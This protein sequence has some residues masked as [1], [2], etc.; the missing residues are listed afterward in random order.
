MNHAHDRFHQGNLG[1]H[2][3]TRRQPLLQAAKGGVLRAAGF[4]AFEMCLALAGLLGVEQPF[5]A[6]DQIVPA[7]SAVHIVYVLLTVSS[8]LSR[9]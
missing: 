1:S 2:S 5:Q 9:A 4:A 7:F 3:A 6:G 8:A